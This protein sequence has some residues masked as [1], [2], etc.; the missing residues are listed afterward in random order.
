MSTINYVN[1]FY[2]IS[3]WG[4]ESSEKLKALKIGFR[5]C[6]RQMASETLVQVAAVYLGCGAL[7]RKLPKDRHREPGAMASWQASCLQ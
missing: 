5:G 6:N 3:P 2:S 7:V 4:T 1:R